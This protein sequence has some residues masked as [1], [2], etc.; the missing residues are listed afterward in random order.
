MNELTRQT[1]FTTENADIAKGNYGNI[2]RKTTENHL[3][4]TKMANA[5]KTGDKQ[6][7]NEME[8]LKQNYS[9]IFEG[10][11]RGVVRSKI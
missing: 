10:I 5:I 7:P 3:G 2:L 1:K 6:D 8:Q 11:S 4:L 9:N